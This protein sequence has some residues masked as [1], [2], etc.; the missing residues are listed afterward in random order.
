MKLPR[1][2]CTEKRGAGDGTF[3]S[4]YPL[5]AGSLASAVVVGDYDGDGI[6]DLVVANEGDESVV[7]LRGDGLGNFL[8]FSTVVAGD[9]ADHISVGDFNGDGILDVIVTTPGTGDVTILLGSP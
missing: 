7:M 8:P 5:Y 2:P 3:T 4:S 1:L 6:T 9:G